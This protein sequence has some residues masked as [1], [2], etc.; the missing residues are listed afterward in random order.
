MK[1]FQFLVTLDDEQSNVIRELGLSGD[2][3][4]ED[5]HQLIFSSFGLEAGELASFYFTNDDW[6]QLDEIP[7][8][9]FDESTLLTMSQ[10]KIEEVFNTHKKLLYVYDFFNM[11]TFYVELKSKGEK[12]KTGILNSIGILPSSAPNKDFSGSEIME[13]YRNEGAFHSPDGD[14]DFNDDEDFEDSFNNE[15]Y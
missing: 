7:M 4:L 11:W 2:A 14:E 9:A 3:V 8:M 1:N 15:E 13:G 10:V 5:L 12:L 6:E